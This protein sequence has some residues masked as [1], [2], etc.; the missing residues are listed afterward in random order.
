VEYVIYTPGRLIEMG[1]GHRCYC[2][3]DLFMVNCLAGT[4][5]NILNC[6][7]EGFQIIFSHFF[8][9]LAF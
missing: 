8:H 3:G 2:E 7:V 9:A 1:W 4:R 6:C 5:L